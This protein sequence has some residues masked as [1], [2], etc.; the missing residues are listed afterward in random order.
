[1]VE[2]MILTIGIRAGIHMLLMYA[3]NESLICRMK[4][5]APSHN[6]EKFREH[7]RWTFSPRYRG[8]I[9]AVETLRLLF[10]P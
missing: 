4:V 3:Q 1:M 10:R 2:S 7:S 6:G 9:G 8:G 5:W